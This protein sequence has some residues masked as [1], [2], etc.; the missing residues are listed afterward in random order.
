M[1][2]SSSGPRGL[3]VTEARQRFS[4][5]EWKTLWD[6]FDAV[7]DADSG[8]ALTFRCFHEMVLGRSFVPR[9]LAF[10][11]F[12]LFGSESMSV[13]GPFEGQS[14][15]VL[16]KSGFM[17]GM[18]LLLR[19]SDRERL[20]FMFEVYD[21]DQDGRVSIEELVRAVTLLQTSGLRDVIKRMG[22][23]RKV[24]TSIMGSADAFYY[25]DFERWAMRTKLQGLAT[26][27]HD[28]HPRARRRA[29]GTKRAGPRLA[30]GV[31][32]K[33][34]RSIWLRREGSQLARDTGFDDMQ[35]SALEKQY[36]CLMA[37]HAYAGAETGDEIS[38]DA[39]NENSERPPQSNE[40]Q[41]DSKLSWQA[42]SAHITPE[43]DAKAAS[44][45]YRGFR[46]PARGQAAPRGSR[47]PCVTLS[48]FVRGMS[49]CVRR[50][51]AGRVD[52]LFDAMC[53]PC[54]PSTTTTAAPTEEAIATRRA[55]ETMIKSLAV[56]STSTSTT[57][58]KTLQRSP[59]SAGAL[60]QR[61]DDA[62]GGR[63]GISRAEWAAAASGPLKR[64]VRMAFFDRVGAYAATEMGLRPITPDG[65]RAVLL[66]L[67]A[68]PMLRAGDEL[69]VISA[70]WLDRWAAYT[71]LRQG[72]RA[73]AV[74]STGAIVSAP[75]DSPSWPA[76]TPPIDEK[77]KEKKISRPGPVD[78]A[79]IMRDNSHAALRRGLREGKDY[80]VV[81]PR[82]WKALSYWYG[83]GP[84][85]RRALIARAT[86]V[87]ETAGI[88][89]SPRALV[90]E[91]YPLALECY[92]ID[93]TTHVTVEVSRSA[94][95]QSL[96]AKV[97]ERAGLQQSRMRLWSYRDSDGRPIDP[98]MLE[99]E[100]TC[101]EAGLVDGQQL[102]IEQQGKGKQWEGIPEVAEKAKQAQAALADG[103]AARAP[104]LQRGSQA[105]A[106][107]SNRAG[108][109]GH[110]SGRA[111]AARGVKGLYNLGN[112]CF[113][114][115]ALQ[116]LNAAVP[117]SRYFLNDLYLREINEDNPLGM[118]GRC[119]L[120][121][122]HHIKSL[123][124]AQGAVSPVGVKYIMAKKNPR[125]GGYQQQDAQELLS[126]LMDGLHE[127]LNRVKKKPYTQFPDSAG[128]KDCVVAREHIR[129]YLKRN[130]SVIVDLFAG[131]TK[132][133]L[134]W[135]GVEG[136]SSVKFE[137]F[138]MLSLPMPTLRHVHV[139]VTVVFRNAIKTPLRVSVQVPIGANIGDVK[140]AIAELDPRLGL[141]DR[142]LLIC[143]VFSSYLFA[144]R[145]RVSAV[146]AFGTRAARNTLYAYEVP[147][148]EVETGEGGAD[149][150]EGD[151][152]GAED[153]DE[154]DM[155]VTVGKRFD[156]RDKYGKWYSAT[157]TRLFPDRGTAR[158]A[159]DGYDS[160]YDETVRIRGSD[161]WARLGTR[162]VS[163]MTPHQE[164]GLPSHIAQVVCLHRRMERPRHNFLL[165]RRRARLFGIPI[166]L[167]V[168]KDMTGRDLY[169]TV[170]HKT[171]RFTSVPP[172]FRERWARGLSESGALR[173]TAG[174][175]KAAATRTA[176][177]KDPAGDAPEPPFVLRYVN[178][179]GDVCSKSTWDEFCTGTLVE[180]TQKP[181]L[182]SDQNHIAIDWNPHFVHAGLNER[183]LNEVLP[184]PS[185]A[186][187]AAEMQ[188]HMDIGKCFQHFTEAE[189]IKEVYCAKVKKHL[190]ATKRFEL[191]STPPV[192]VVHLKRLVRG[193]KIQTF[194]DFPL[195]GFDPSPYL[196][197]D[198]PG[199]SVQDLAREDVG[200][201]IKNGSPRAPDGP[202]PAPNARRSTDT[203]GGGEETGSGEAPQSATPDAL[204]VAKDPS[205]LYD[206]FG[207]INH[208]GNGGGGHYVA[209]AK[210][211]GN[212]G[213]GW[214]RFDDSHVT[215]MS[216]KHVVTQY[217]Y[218]I[219]YKRRD[220]DIDSW[221]F[222]SKETRA[223]LRR[224]LSPDEARLAEVATG[225]GSW[226]EGCVVA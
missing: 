206:L 54:K 104:K 118:K 58:Q 100:I 3:P 34:E 208:Y 7:A 78:N 120:Y 132:S 133:T 5:R 158:V 89:T 81:S 76:P 22:S 8:R 66:S 207:V 4:R 180:F 53:M 160:R 36:Y 224:P 42:L 183:A 52:Y 202:P 163:R 204:R 137:P 18:G 147:V 169:D 55:V 37:S 49:K 20:R 117:L 97:C 73:L 85:V 220:L 27:L 159:F 166:L 51:A 225:A 31:C 119:A 107:E 200:S 94:T 167:F 219:F 59:S 198:E 16:R 11:V 60:A 48:G 68:P 57:T 86:P 134:E 211:K 106:E 193:G 91:L 116:C 96:K 65:E 67:R 218:M 61:L 13:G 101:L 165:G 21:E 130:R 25:A 29:N 2:N 63:D 196:T 191:Y 70:S 212:R 136:H 148:I 151:G 143:D 50:G 226:V 199:V 177:D 30:A 139:K 146:A 99:S 152:D 176:R 149:A 71:G 15:R 131:V 213:T 162:A 45:L 173:A 142:R 174:Q 108:T 62:F 126:F 1:G 221:G 186:V 138:T 150:Q 195:R 115:A 10:R 83:G 109:D 155:K 98:A 128:R 110:A 184:H 39:S 90:V 95:L 125:F 203:D 179:R 114:N 124:R 123:W 17:G 44:G 6:G 35:L 24:A 172:E 201:D 222:L 33:E 74:R 171:R 43:V 156:V 168:R 111:R 216:E 214:Y 79:P 217:A 40:Q 145:S 75:T 164:L 182:L 72:A 190:P 144:V 178:R 84:M 88:P 69:F 80:Y 102:L 122:G 87:D 209:V 32:A 170:W 188:K 38:D 113:M 105:A 77:R 175:A 14:V 154:D 135:E 12:E 19:G 103:K 153:D 9:Y 157:V 161:R 46:G 140:T 192:L 129:C 215:R 189:K 93:K 41:L 92:T 112:T 28:M 197:G 141:D 223:L 185:L 205:K 121:Y 187:A 56:V 64:E 23:C 26:W 194:V 181:L 127:D 210:M 47:S 82:V